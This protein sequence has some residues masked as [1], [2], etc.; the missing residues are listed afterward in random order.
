MRMLSISLTVAIIVAALM[1]VGAIGVY[2]YYA[3]SLPPA[4]QLLTRAVAQSTKIFDRNGELLYEVFDPNGGRRTVAPIS[5][6]PPAL[7]YATIATEDKTFYTNPG[8]DWSGI[9][10]AVYYLARYGKPVAGGGSTIT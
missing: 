5:K 3:Q 10:R 1:I 9:A 7:K 4:E 8:V 2:G 6:M